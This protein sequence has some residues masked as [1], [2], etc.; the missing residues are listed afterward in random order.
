MRSRKKL[1]FILVFVL[2]LS[3]F[4]IASATG[5]KE[6]V[7]AI[8]NGEITII[9]DK[10]VQTFKDENGNKVLPI[11]YNGTTYLPVRAVASMLDLDV[12][13]DGTTKTIT[14]GGKQ[15]CYLTE[16]EITK[17]IYGED[18]TSL[19]LDSYNLTATIEEKEVIYKTGI[20]LNSVNG[21]ASFDVDNV[22]FFDTNNYKSLTYT[23]LA[24]NQTLVT[25]LYGMDSNGNIVPISSFTL[26]ADESLCTEVDISMYEKVGFGTNSDYGKYDG[27]LRIF[28]PILE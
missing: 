19:I 16:Q 13:Y 21:G 10:E 20:R 26:K 7:S 1:V 25:V 5:L 24:T 23:A 6:K 11:S 4:T 17:P 12:D 27:Y 2:I 22:Y 14:L 18:R 28:D 15:P 8:L 9:Y 3:T